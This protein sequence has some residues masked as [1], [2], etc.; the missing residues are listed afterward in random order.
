VVIWYIFPVLEYCTE[1]NLATLLQDETG[2]AKFE[3]RAEIEISSRKK[4]VASQTV[5]DSDR[6]DRC[7]DTVSNK[8]PSLV[9]RKLSCL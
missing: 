5:I 7:I 4:S 3:I 9:S 2:V 6:I 1:K 8:L